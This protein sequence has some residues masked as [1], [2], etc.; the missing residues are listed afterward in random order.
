M[1]P[2]AQRGWWRSTVH[3]EAVDTWFGKLRPALPA[4]IGDDGTCRNV[5]RPRIVQARQGHENGGRPAGPCWQAD[6]GRGIVTT[7]QETDPPAHPGHRDPLITAAA[8]GNQDAWDELV[9]RHA[10][11]LW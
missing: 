5:G 10:Q 9:D 8:A 1:D 3:S 7:R 11:H 2:N 6:T 4:D